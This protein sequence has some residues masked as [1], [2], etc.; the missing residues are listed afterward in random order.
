[1]SAYKNEHGF[2][3]LFSLLIMQLVSLL[4]LYSISSI[5]ESL[6]SERGSWQRFVD[7]QRFYAGIEAIEHLEKT[8]G[9]RINQ[10]NPYVIIKRP[11]EWWK[12]FGCSENLSG[13]RYDYV[14]E[15]LGNDPC[16]YIKTIN[17]Q[18]VTSDYFRLTFRI[19]S[20][21]EVNK[22]VYFQDTILL[23]GF[24]KPVCKHKPRYLRAGRQMRREL[25]EI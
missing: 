19:Q 17:N 12:E 21:R 24:V 13:F 14:A 4:A 9:C 20:L 5:H 10:M 18:V 15:Y 7:T 3:L 2:I 22:L 1:M 23:P 16:G 25:M 11:L 8:T 6:K